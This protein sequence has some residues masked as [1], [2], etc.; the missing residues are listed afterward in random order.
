MKQLRNITVKFKAKKKS[1]QTKEQI[2]QGA[3]FLQ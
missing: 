2:D 1:L 3:Y